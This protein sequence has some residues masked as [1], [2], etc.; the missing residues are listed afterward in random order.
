MRVQMELKSRGYYDGP[1][2]GRMSIDTR[3]SI[4]AFQLVQRLPETGNMDNA[5]LAKLGITY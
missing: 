2:D 5:T 4:R 3:N 1:I